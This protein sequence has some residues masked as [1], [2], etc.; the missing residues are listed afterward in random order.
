FAEAGVEPPNTYDELVEV[1]KKI[2]EVFGEGSAIAIAGTNAW[3]LIHNWAII[4]WAFGGDLLSPDN[5]QAVF[6]EQPGVE[7]MNWYVDLVS[8]GLASK[9][10]AEYNQPQADAAFIS[11]NVAMAFMGPW[12][13]A[14][15]EVDNPD[16]NY[17]IVE[18][19][20]GPAGR[21]AFSGGSNLVILADSPNKEAAKKWIQYLLRPE[22]LTDYTKNLTH[23]LPT[24]YEAYDDP[25]YN[26]GVWQTFKKTLSYA[27]AYP[28]L[29]V[30]GDIENAIVGE[31]KQ[32]LSDY[33]EGKLTDVQRYLDAAAGQVNR[34]L[35]R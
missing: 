30:W 11:G 26:E 17:G 21:A 3:D 15:I 10:S 23:M 33:V 22:V 29:G 34:A 5:K 1:G 8:L 12:N 20:A 31:Y 7:A 6:N 28:P 14:G 32:I 19:P 16:L 35:A 9:A 27:T 4:L 24:T 25:Y 18:P 2:V 13:I